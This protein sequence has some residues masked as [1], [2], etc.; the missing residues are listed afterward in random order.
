MSAEPAA[1]GAE[2]A[3]PGR[4]T[5]FAF[6]NRVFR[7]PGA[8]F[9]LEASSREPV[10]TVPLGDNRGAIP[11]PTLMDAFDVPR[12]SDDARLLDLVS[13]SLAFVKVI[14]PGESIP[15]ELLDGTAS[16]SVEDR[17]RARARARYW[18]AA[19]LAH[20]DGPVPQVEVLEA[21]LDEPEI[22]ERRLRAAEALAAAAGPSCGGG[23][24]AAR[25]IEALAH[26]QAY[27]EALRERCG[28]VQEMRDKIEALRRVYSK[29]RRLAD[30]LGQIALQV[31]EP[32]AALERPFR[33]ADGLL[34]DVA[35]AV[36]AVLPSIRAI[37]AVR[38]RVHGMLMDWDEILKPW[39]HVKAQRSAEAEGMIRQTRRFLARRVEIGSVWS[40]R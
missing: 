39:A 2:A 30:E 14:R 38:D 10:F 11:F 15:R 8:Y 7:I 26:E 34:R 18:A 17:H 19:L 16:W 29:E 27:V 4:S 21:E 35:G 12:G 33:D 37:R 36:E 31:R 1:E 9:A 13:R 23:D 22:R 40:R 20:A 3:G 5:H 28:A 24:E 25:R 6:S 32:A